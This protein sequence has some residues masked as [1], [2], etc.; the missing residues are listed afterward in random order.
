MYIFFG[1]FCVARSIEI[2]TN[3]ETELIPD[4]D[5]PEVVHHHEEEEEERKPKRPPRDDLRNP[6]WLEDE[7]LGDGQI[8]YINRKEAV[9]WGQLINRYLYPITMDKEEKKQLTEE[10]KSLRNNVCG[11]AI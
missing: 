8:K 11:T 9:F 10:L 2:Q 4:N 6:A 3:T 7:R 1:F 5:I